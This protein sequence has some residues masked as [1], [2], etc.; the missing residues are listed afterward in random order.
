MTWLVSPV[1]PTNGDRK[2]R[3][4]GQRLSVTLI[5][6][7]YRDIYT[8][9]FEPHPELDE[10]ADAYRINLIDLLRARRA[11]FVRI[12]QVRDW[13]RF[14]YWFRTQ[15]RVREIKKIGDFGY[16]EDKFNEEDHSV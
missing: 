4:S 2:Q 15:V 7:H 5:D 3:G 8:R 11:A 1:Y 13:W 9:D 12:Q 10:G 6:L 16:M 14:W